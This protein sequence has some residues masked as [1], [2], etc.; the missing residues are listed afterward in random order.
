MIVLIEYLAQSL[1]FLSTST[2]Q[3]YNQINKDIP[4]FFVDNY[5]IDDWNRKLKRLNEV[6]KNKIEAV[7]KRNFSSDNYIQKCLK[8]Y[9]TILNS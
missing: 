8:I 6:S 2:G 9:Q 4:Q 5:N 7:Y 3:V 1:P